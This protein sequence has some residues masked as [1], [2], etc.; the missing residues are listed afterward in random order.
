M[1]RVTI[2][3]LASLAFIMV[4]IVLYASILFFGG[5]KLVVSFD[6]I[7]VSGNI[8]NYIFEKESSIQNIAPKATKE[9]ICQD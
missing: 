7:E 9:I 1:I 3:I 8:E 5:D 4:G 2:Y 6:D